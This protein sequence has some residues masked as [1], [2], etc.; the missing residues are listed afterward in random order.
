MPQKRQKAS[1]LESSSAER[2]RDAD[3]HQVEQEP[4]MCPCSKGQEHPELHY[5]ELCQQDEKNNLSAPSAP[6]VDT[7]PEFSFLGF[8]VYERHR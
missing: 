3:R 5:K 2:P 8:P 1:W 7:N 4:A 6:L